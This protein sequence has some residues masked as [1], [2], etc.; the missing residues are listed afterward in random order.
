MINLLPP[1]EKEKR[2]QEKQ[3]KLA[4]VLGIL[5]IA[6]ILS[7]GLILF[8]IELYI[9]NQIETK[10]TLIEMERQGNY[11][12]QTLQ[13]KIGVINKNLLALN[14]F[15]KDQFMV[16]LLLEQV[17]NLLQQGAHL[18]VFSYHEDGSRVMLSG[19]AVD[20]DDAYK[21]REQLREQENFQEVSFA[22]GDWFQDKGISFRVN[23]ILVPE[24]DSN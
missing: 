12:I 11:Q 8:S 5:I 21:F 24:R 10:K 23:F 17:S 20:V 6:P 16:S 3:L 14:T 2:S 1:A 19:Y 15:Y 18:R 9:N 13:R 4:W 7:F 22:L